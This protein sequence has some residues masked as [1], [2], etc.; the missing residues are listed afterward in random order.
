M[1]FRADGGAP[2]GRAAREKRGRPA[3]PQ[4]WGPTPVD[5]SIRKGVGLS[6]T[7]HVRR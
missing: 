5:R 4:Q 6:A 1:R 7:H 2:I 3:P